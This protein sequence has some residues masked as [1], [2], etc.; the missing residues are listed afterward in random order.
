MLSPE[1]R[2]AHAPPSL[3]GV[4]GLAFLLGITLVAARLGAPWVALLAGTLLL[5]GLTARIWARYALH[6]LVYTRQGAGMGAQGPGDQAPTPSS[7]ARHRAGAPPLSP[8]SRPLRAFCGDTLALETRLG[9]RKLLPLPWVEVWER[10]PLALDPGEELVESVEARGQ[11]WLCQGASLWPY[12][13]ARWQHRLECRHR[14]VFTLGAVR[15]RA[16]DPFGLGEREALLPARLQAIVYPRVVP[17]RRLALPL[18]H[19]TLDARSRR[20]L[21]TDPTRT[22]WLRAYQPGDPPRLVHWPATA[23]QG[24]L[25]VRVP[26]PT[27][28]L[29]VSLVLDAA[30]FDT[31]LA[32]YR[33][34]LF[35]LAVSALASIAIYLQQA[36]QPVG[37]YANSRPPITLPPSANPAQLETLLEWLAR[38]ELGSGTRSRAAGDGEA[39]MGVGATPKGAVSPPPSPISH[40]LTAAPRGSAVILTVSELAYDLPATLAR[41]EDGGRE[42]VVLLAG[43]GHRPPPIPLERVVLLTPTS[44]LAALLEGQVALRGAAQ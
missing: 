40:P 38:I 19:P 15:V 2:P 18:R 43:S 37:L 31:V 11:G 14:G 34:T 41:L 21:I 7:A 3:F 27:T 5:V 24:A 25:Q 6:G 35:E 36:G 33:E 39:G 26:E 17:L 29:Q 23:R 8:E 4:Y 22:A 1:T 30:S 32:L 9:N 28:T 16:G 13:R 44:D 12:Q 10:L 20:G 42:V